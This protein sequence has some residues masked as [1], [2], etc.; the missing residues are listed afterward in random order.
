M[1][2]ARASDARAEIP[3]SPAFLHLESMKRHNVS[4]NRS[5]HCMQVEL[6]VH[7]VLLEAKAVQAR[8]VPC[9]HTPSSQIRKKGLNFLQPH[10]VCADGLRGLNLK[11]ALARSTVI[12]DHAGAE[13]HVSCVLRH[14]QKVPAGSLQVVFYLSGLTC[15]DE[16]F[17][18]KAGAH[19]AASRL[20][21]ALISPDT[22]P[23]GLNVDG[24]ADSYDFGV[25]AG[26]YLNATTE[27]WQNWRMYDY[28]TKELPALLRQLPNLDIDNVR[29][30]P[31]FPHSPFLLHIGCQIY[32]TPRLQ[33]AS[34]RAPVICSS[35]GE[36]VRPHRDVKPA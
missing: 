17:V 1:R 20:G 16:N 30:W 7:L 24:E 34:R 18:Q 9:I 10:L 33:N 25:G 31:P 26:F 19:R 29:P 23:R 8:I 21:L 6:N 15:T 35:Q 2:R 11:Y 28:V 4:T 27:K 3:L 32:H 14:L 5:S 13:Q 36:R 12:W 22:S